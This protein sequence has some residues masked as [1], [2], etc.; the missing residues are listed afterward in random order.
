MSVTIAIADPDEQG[1]EHIIL[2]AAGDP[3]TPP[4]W[5]SR[6]DAIKDLQGVIRELRL[7]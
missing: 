5:W 6:E 4:S 2:F 3:L 1:D 7:S